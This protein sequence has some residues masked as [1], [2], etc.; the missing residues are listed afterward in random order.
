[1]SLYDFNPG[2]PAKRPTRKEQAPQKGSVAARAK[3]TASKGSSQAARLKITVQQPDQLDA[4]ARRL[5]LS[6]AAVFNLA[7]AELAAKHGIR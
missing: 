6:K 5:G 7:L 4:L 3:P 1:M 2:K